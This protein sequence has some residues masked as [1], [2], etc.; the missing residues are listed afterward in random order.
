MLQTAAA[1]SQRP[2]E[3]PDVAPATWNDAGNLRTS[4]QRHGDVYELLIRRDAEGVRWEV[5][6][7]GCDVAAGELPADA[8]ESQLRADVHRHGVTIPVRVTWDRG[9]W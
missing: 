9:L 8:T 1:T 7:D 6:A 2:N 3:S 5:Y 4:W